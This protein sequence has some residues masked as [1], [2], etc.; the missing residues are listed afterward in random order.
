MGVEILNRFEPVFVLIFQ[1]INY[2]NIGLHL[3]IRH[4]TQQLVLSVEVC[5]LTGVKEEKKKVVFY[6]YIFVHF[7]ANNMG[8]AKQAVPLE[9]RRSS[10]RLAMKPKAATVEAKKK[11][12]GKKAPKAKKAKPAEN[13]NPKTEEPKAEATEAK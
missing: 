10:P 3:Y 4:F 8:K 7:S 2:K 9:Q 6:G 12:A 13:G 11:A 1:R 5:D